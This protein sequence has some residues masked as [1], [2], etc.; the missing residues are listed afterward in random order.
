M[1][2]EACTTRL[3]QFGQRPADRLDPG[4]I[5]DE[6]WQIRLREVA[7]VIR[8]LL[9][10]HQRRPAGGRIPE[11]RFLHE[12]RA[13]PS[14]GDVALDFVLNR[15]LDV[16]EGI[17]VLELSL[18]AERRCAGGPDRHVGVAAQTAF[19]H[20]AV[21]DPDGD[22]DLADAAE[23]FG[24]VGRRPQIR[25]GHDLDQRHAAPVEVQ[26]GPPRGIWQSVMQRLSGVLLHVDRA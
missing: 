9:G 2:D 11:P 14:G 4:R 5:D 19:F 18:D 23:R 16:T 7:V 6:G 22:Q 21:V 17:E 12:R 24:G 15:A 3:G 26:V 8:F 13:L 25:L 20:V 10:P 1:R